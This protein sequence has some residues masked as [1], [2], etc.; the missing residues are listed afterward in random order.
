MK[1]FTQRDRHGENFWGR[2]HPD[3]TYSEQLQGKDKV[4]AMD[5]SR[6]WENFKQ[7]MIT[8]HGKNNNLHLFTKVITNK[9]LRLENE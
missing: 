9:Q 7:E 2:L 1:H 6:D 3:R 5:S 4:H 8:M